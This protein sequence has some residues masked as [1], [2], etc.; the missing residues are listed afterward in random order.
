M[1]MEDN[2]YRSTRNLPYIAPGCPGFKNPGARQGHYVGASSPEEAVAKIAACWPGEIIW[3]FTV[4]K[5]EDKSDPSTAMWWTIEDG[6][7]GEGWP[8]WAV[9]DHEGF[10]MTPFGK[11]NGSNIK[12]S[13]ETY[14]WNGGDS[15]ETKMRQGGKVEGN[16]GVDITLVRKTFLHESEH[17]LKLMQGIADYAAEELAREERDA[18]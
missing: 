2:I 1:T 16:D 18:S 7:E 15:L 6:L 10:V 11:L 5:P 14:G 9:I 3:G 8:K 4:Q 13:P 17:L 12:M